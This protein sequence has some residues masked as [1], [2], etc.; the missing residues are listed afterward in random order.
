MS[1]METPLMLNC[2]VTELAIAA[3]PEMPDAVEVKTT[4]KF[5]VMASNGKPFGIKGGI[6]L[7]G[8]GDTYYSIAIGVRASFAFPNE[9]DEGKS[10]E[11]LMTEAPVRVFDFVRSYLNQVT[12]CFPYGSVQIPPMEFLA[13]QE[14][15]TE[16]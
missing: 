11:Y 16:D 5:H 2:E 15:T 13:G 14:E 6:D 4:G 3:K 12:S 9:W 1:N 7:K 8:E 10:T